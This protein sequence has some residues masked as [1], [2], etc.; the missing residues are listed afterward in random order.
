MLGEEYD[1]AHQDSASEAGTSA[2]EQSGSV[3]F[4]MRE[5]QTQM[6]YTL[7]HATVRSYC[8]S[9]PFSSPIDSTETTSAVPTLQSDSPEAA[10][11]RS[12]LTQI[13]ALRPTP[14]LALSILSSV[15]SYPSSPDSTLSVPTLVSGSTPPDGFLGN[16]AE[17]PER[18]KQGHRA[19]TH[20]SAMSINGA[21][22][23]NDLSERAV[24]FGQDSTMKQE[25]L[26]S[27][28]LSLLNRRLGRLNSAHY[29]RQE[30][31]TLVESAQLRF[32]PRPARTAEK[33]SLVNAKCILSR[34]LSEAEVLR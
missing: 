9:I 2:S 8:S 19:Q 3:H 20:P 15:E 21:V 4:N 34:W 33:G 17:S 26:I 27:F 32:M 25:C 30:A 1:E 18:R 11:I 31:L 12:V 22:P 14:G 23:N 29:Y 13:H 5:R 7:A 10:Q 6:C 24:A 16:D 28:Y